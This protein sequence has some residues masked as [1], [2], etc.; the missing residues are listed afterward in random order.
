MKATETSP[1]KYVLVYLGERAKAPS[2]F[3]AN[4]EQVK[5]MDYKTMTLYNPKFAFFTPSP[6]PG[7]AQ[8]GLLF[9]YL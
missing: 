6:S 7:S 8:I 3:Q 1:R 9:C 5:N 2:K 4:L